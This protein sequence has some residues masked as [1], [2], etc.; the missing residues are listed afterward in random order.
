MLLAIATIHQWTSAARAEDKTSPSIET[1]ILAAVIPPYL[2]EK[3]GPGSASVGV[4]SELV[5]EMARRIGHSGRITYVPWARAQQMTREARDGVPRLIIPL[6]R[7]EAREYQYKWVAPLLEDEALL[8]SVKGKTPL[9]TSAEQAKG[10]PA[11]ALLGSP[12]EALL[13]ELNFTTVDAGVDEET[14]AR[15]LNA[16]RLQVWFV[17]RMV[18]P[19]LYK[20]AG[21]NASDLQY[22]VKLRTND[23]YLGASP[24]LSDAEADR[25][26]NALRAMQDDGTYEK[27]VS[28]YRD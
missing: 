26:R 3:D 8:V 10:M 5:K 14:N 4:I 22:G 20:Q 15:K 6:T 28:K 12:Q 24:N 18:A 9:I 11:G 2:F 13:R 1:E 21:F 16:G 17:A 7:T 25:W 23:L 19:F 27:I